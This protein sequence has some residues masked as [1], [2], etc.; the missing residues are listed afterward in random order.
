MKIIRRWGLQHSANNQK[1]A[2]NRPAWVK[3][4]VLLYIARQD[5]GYAQVTA[6]QGP[7]VDN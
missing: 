3:R 4:T 5:G 7:G 1:M 2:G 6:S